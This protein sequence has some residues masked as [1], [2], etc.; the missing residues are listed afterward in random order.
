MPKHVIG[1]EDMIYSRSMQAF[2]FFSAKQK[3]AGQICRSA[4]NSWAAQRRPP[5]EMENF[6]LRRWRAHHPGCHLWRRSMTVA[7]YPL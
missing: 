7:N 3:P 1:R 4:L 6:V 5:F 2:Y